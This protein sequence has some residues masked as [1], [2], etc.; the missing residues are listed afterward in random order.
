MG[1]FYSHS[2][3]SNSNSLSGPFSTPLILEAFYD[4]SCFYIFS[5]YS[6][7]ISV[8][9]M[10]SYSFSNIS[11]HNDFNYYLVDTI[12]ISGTISYYL[13]SENCSYS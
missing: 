8:G 5:F 6:F 4:D 7:F 3:N 1:D 11:E 10:F 9:L 2:L 12:S 13:S